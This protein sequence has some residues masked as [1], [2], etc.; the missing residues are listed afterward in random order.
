MRLRAVIIPEDMT[1]IDRAAALTGISRC[2]IWRAI[3]R[4]DLHADTCES[5]Y[6][7]GWRYLV[8][9]SDVD[10]L[11]LKPYHCAGELKREPPTRFGQVLWALRKRGGWTQTAVAQRAGLS[12]NIVGDYERGKRMPRADTLVAL[13]EAL[14]CSPA[15]ERELWEAYDDEHRARKERSAGQPLPRIVHPPEPRS[16]AGH[17][18]RADND[19]VFSKSDKAA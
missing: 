15:D 13:T 11:P 16:T 14:R 1:T 5:A 12:P 8:K 10:R 3:Q 19:L 2:T 4:G 6:G 17:P 18:W 7:R 9:V